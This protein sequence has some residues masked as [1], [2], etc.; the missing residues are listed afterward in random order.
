MQTHEDDLHFRSQFIEELKNRAE[1]AKQAA[2]SLLTSGAE[3][4]E[5]LG[6]WKGKNGMHCRHLPPDPQDILRISIGGGNHLP[7][8]M[9]YC[10]IRGT[11]GQCIALLE[12][13]ISALRECPE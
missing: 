12:M 9:N 10:V 11:V 5:E 8:T 6:R 1:K 4:E 2:A 3:S 7:V 13:A